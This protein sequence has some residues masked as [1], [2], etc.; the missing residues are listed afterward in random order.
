[1]S[2]SDIYAKENFE[3][4]TEDPAHSFAMEMGIDP[5]FHTFCMDQLEEELRMEESHI[6]SSDKVGDDFLVCSS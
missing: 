1:M 3:S 2:D 4:I 6:I 5:D